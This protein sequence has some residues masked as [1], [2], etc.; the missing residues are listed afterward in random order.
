MNTGHVGGDS[1][2]LGR[3]D[4]IGGLNPRHRHRFASGVG[5]EHCRFAFLDLEPLAPQGIEDVGLVRHDKRVLAGGVLASLR[6]ALR[7]RGNLEITSGTG[8]MVAR[9]TSAN[10]CRCGASQSK[11][12]CDGSHA[13]IGFP[14]GNE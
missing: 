11:P 7:L 9:I 3:L 8:R 6:N 1:V 13:R 12:F 5:F 10:L 14:A 4:P 2:L